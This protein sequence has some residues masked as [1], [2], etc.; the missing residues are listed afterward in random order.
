[1]NQAATGFSA[2]LK[3]L[4]SL[5]L[6][7]Y[8]P[9]IFISLILL[10]GHISF[11]I[12]QSYKTVLLSVSASMITEMIMARFMQGKWRNLS[13]AYITGISVSILIRSTMYWPYALT[14][15]LSIVSK[16]VLQYQGKHIW[17]PSNFGISWMLFTAPFSVAALSIQWGNN[18]WPMLVIWI[19]G[20]VIVYRAKRYNITITYVISFVF[21]A[22]VRSWFTGDSFLAEVA[23]LTGPMYQLF[24]FFMITDPATT[25]KSK[26]GQM[27]V[28]FL[29]ALVEFVLRMNQFIYAPFYA[30]FIVGPATMIIDKLMA[31]SSGLNTAASVLK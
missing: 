29:I 3:N 19:L 1:M 17:N 12:L 5:L 21:F 8:A 26:K 30:L 20:L 18:I 28:A 25:V 24:I 4:I 7:N 22:L 27:L 10:V 13:S 31:K 11:G 15:V 23:P 6:S 14:A 16:Y 9:P 2:K